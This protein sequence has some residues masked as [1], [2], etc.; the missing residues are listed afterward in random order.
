M[1]LSQLSQAA[2]PCRSYPSQRKAAADPK[3]P[4]R[5]MGDKERYDHDE[6]ADQSASD[7]ERAYLLV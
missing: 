5:V 6:Q 7:Q 2:I 3:K 1:S 4:F